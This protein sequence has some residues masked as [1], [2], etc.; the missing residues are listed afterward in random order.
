MWREF[1]NFLA[2]G[3]E[4]LVTTVLLLSQKFFNIGRRE[5]LHK[6]RE[7][8]EKGTPELQ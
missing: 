3:D 6:K 4:H 5:K 7:I 2:N 8:H 1:V